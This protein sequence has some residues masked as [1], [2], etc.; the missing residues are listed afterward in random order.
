VQRGSS[1]LDL[2]AGRGYYSELLALVVGPTGRVVSH[3]N[4]V[5]DGVGEDSRRF[6]ISAAERRAVRRRA[7]SWSSNRAGSTSCC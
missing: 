2:F 1:A 4:G 3:N 6:G 7:T 5:L